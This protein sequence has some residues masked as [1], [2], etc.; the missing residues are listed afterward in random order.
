[1]SE[2][3][4]VFVKIDKYKEILEVVEVINKKIVNVKQLLS[5][6]EELKNKEEEE[7][8]NWEK[9]MDEI[10]HKTELIKEQISEG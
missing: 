3:N 4:H 5:D 7:I 9:S 1:M 8:M 2:S 6:L 10:T